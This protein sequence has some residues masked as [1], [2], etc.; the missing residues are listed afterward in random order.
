MGLHLVEDA[1]T[2]TFL[3]NTQFHSSSHPRDLAGAHHGG[4]AFDGVGLAADGFGIGAAHGLD[5]GIGVFH[6]GGDDLPE[7]VERHGAAQVLEDDRIEDFSGAIAVGCGRSFD[8]GT[9]RKRRTDCLG[10]EGLGQN[11]VITLDG[12]RGGGAHGQQDG[13]GREPAQAVSQVGTGEAGHAQIGQHAVGRIA[14]SE[15]LERLLAAGGLQHGESIGLQENRGDGE[16][17]GII[18]DGED[19]ERRGD[20]AR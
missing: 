1:H 7:G 2:I 19:R 8:G 10:R 17:H 16:A 5:A 18:V 3:V 12:R 4:S 13:A 6:E 15:E 14:L 20:R 9:K 11:A